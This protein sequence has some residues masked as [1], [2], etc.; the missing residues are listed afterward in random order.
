MHAL[1]TEAERR[2]HQVETRTVH[3]RGRAV[4]EMVAVIRGRTLPLANRE[5]TT[6]VP[7]EPTAEEMSGND[8]SLGPLYPSTTTS[9][10]DVSNWVRLPAAVPDLVRLRRQHTVGPGSTPGAPPA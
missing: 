2:R 8:A 5:R 1:L 10:A 7:R 3:R 6:K 4:Q 9:S